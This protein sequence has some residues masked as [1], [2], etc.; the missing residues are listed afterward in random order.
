MKKVVKDNKVAIL[1]SPGYGAGWYSWNPSYPECLF[2]PEIVELVK[3]NKHKEIN[4]ELMKV[5]LN[6]EDNEEFDFYCGGAKNLTIE[7]LEQGT[8]FDID[9][10][11][12]SEC[13]K[14]FDKIR[15][16]A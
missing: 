16:I 1:Y 9:E 13:I 7:W 6:Q 12:G 10:Y 15:L 11:D 8:H 3:E 5:L 2:L 14:T 4:E